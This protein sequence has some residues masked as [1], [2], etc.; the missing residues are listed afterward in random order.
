M[1]SSF[2]RVTILVRLKAPGIRY[3]P[4]DHLS[5]CPLNSSDLVTKLLE[6]LP[7]DTP[8]P[9][10]LIHVEVAKKGTVFLF[11]AAL[12]IDTK[13]LYLRFIQEPF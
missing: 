11:R 3:T 4:G 12:R 6:K 9:D 2:S 5:L 8:G 7:E 10:K 13:T 1:I